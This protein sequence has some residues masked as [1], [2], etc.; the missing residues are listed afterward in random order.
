[1]SAELQDLSET[2][3]FDRLLALFVGLEKGGK[4]W[5]AATGRKPILFFDFDGRAGALSGRQDVF[6]ITLRDPGAPHMQPDAIN[7]M[8]DYVTRLEQGQ[9]LAQ[10]GFKNASG[11]FPKT[12]VCDSIATMASSAMRYATY[13]NE[14]ELARRISFGSLVVRI[15][16][17]FDAWNSEMSTIESIILRL[18]GLSFPSGQPDIICIL[19]QA[20]QEDKNSTPEKR[21]YTGKLE[22]FPS[23]YRLLLK[24]FNEVWRVEQVPIVVGEGQDQRNSYRPKVFTRPNYR[25]EHAAT[26]LD[27]DDVE[28]PDIQQMI[29][30][31][32]SREREKK[33]F[34]LSQAAT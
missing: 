3:P 22:I 10:L 12:V 28:L 11:K 27:I 18:I 32:Q 2:Q 26:A 19:H 6:A 29:A 9:D 30:K 16:R 21:I 25:F 1:M 20:E 23:R 15:P 7:T 14:K 24:Y 13:T 17:N 5:L 34:L 4:S 33:G 8:L 31:H